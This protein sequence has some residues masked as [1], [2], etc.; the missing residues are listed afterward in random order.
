MLKNLR[1]LRL[2]EGL[3]QKQLAEIINVSQQ[4]INKYENHEVEPTLETLCVLAD[5]FNTTIDFLADR[6]NIES[7]ANNSSINLNQ[8]ES[9]YIKNYRKLSSKDKKTI[10]TLISCMLEEK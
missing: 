5:Y 8:D 1:L 3:S 7:S 4:S 2:R 9:V 6:T 10:H